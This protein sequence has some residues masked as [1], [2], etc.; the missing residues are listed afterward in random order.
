M[1][2]PHEY[3]RRIL[4]A[5]I[6]MTPQILT[7]T[8]YK[9][10]VDSSPAFVPT[11]IHLISTAQGAN[12][13]RNALLGVGGDKG[14][15]HRF[16]EDYCLE[17]ISFASGQVHTITG[18]DGP[19]V[20]DTESAEHNTM[21]ADF[22]T[23][24]VR[25]FTEDNQAALH[26]SLAGGRKTMSYYA[27]YALSLYGRM[28]DRLSHVL[29]AKPFQENKNFF[30]PPPRPQRIAV[31]NT[32]YSTE[33]SQ[34]ILSDIPFVRMRYQIPE[35]LLTGSA[36]FQETVETIQRFSSPETIEIDIRRKQVRLNALEVRMGD[37]DL[38]L[39][40]WMCERRKNGEPPFIPDEDAF[41]DEY[42]QVYA[43]IVGEWSGR[44]E[45]VEEVARGRDAAQ[46]KEWFLQRKSKLKK[47]V[48]LV[49][50]ERAARPFLIQ[51]VEVNG[52]A[53]YVVEMEPK[54]ILIS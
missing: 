32:W 21:T 11:E 53:G 2:Q 31:N 39:Y 38:A 33:E 36:G 3:P 8:L 15:F 9:L 7:E 18:P 51:T 27:G 20:D 30:Y 49:L 26:L 16:C 28:Q 29:V 13:A 24:Q 19:F 50:G 6:G 12:S 1:P 5:V 25:R 46:Q 22:I 48:V 47:A 10:A 52:Q 37:A 4:L 42:I 45:R 44:I 34:I 23:E 54:D 14:E 41:V 40:L 43:R 17:G 35:A